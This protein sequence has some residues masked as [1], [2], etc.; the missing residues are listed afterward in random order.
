M[1][2]EQPLELPGAD[3]DRIVKFINTDQPV[4]LTNKVHGIMGKVTAFFLS[5]QLFREEAICS[6][7]L[8]VGSKLFPYPFAK[9]FQ[10]FARHAD[11]IFICGYKRPGWH[12]QQ[13][14]ES[15]GMKPDPE[16]PDRR[17]ESY[18]IGTIIN[19]HQCIWRRTI[20]TISL[21]TQFTVMVSQVNDQFYASVGNNVMRETRLP[22]D[23]E[24]RFPIGLDIR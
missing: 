21:P 22:G 3:R 17:R 13:M 6:H 18:D 4:G 10:L 16:R 12:P 23:I 14:T 15:I 24:R 7:H 1:L 19:A 11:T 20:V 8:S 2:S 9:M 5:C